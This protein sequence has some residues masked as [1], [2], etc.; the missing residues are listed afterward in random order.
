MRKAIIKNL[1]KQ[2]N[3]PRKETEYITFVCDGRSN[4]KLRVKQ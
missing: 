4:I 2:E 1:I 3:K